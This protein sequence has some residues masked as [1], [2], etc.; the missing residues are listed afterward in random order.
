MILTHKLSTYAALRAPTILGIGQRKNEE[1]VCV[2]LNE[3]IGSKL[4]IQLLK[5]FFT[6][7]RFD[8]SCI[9]YELYK[10]YGSPHLEG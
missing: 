1:H 8:L 10:V 5:S 4:I 7:Q 3:K 6:E 9:G 2:S